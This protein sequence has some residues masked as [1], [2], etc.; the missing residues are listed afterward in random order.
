MFI[1]KINIK[2]FRHIENVELG[3]FNFNTKNSDLIV[4]AGPNGGGKSSMLEL[5]GYAL[6]SSYSLSW[7]LSRTFAGFSFEIAIG[8]NLIEKELI[9]NSLK[10]EL[11]N[12]ESKILD[13][14]QIIDTR[15]DINSQ[16]KERLK[17]ELKVNLKRPYKFQ[18]E[19][20]EYLLRNNVYYRSFEYN[21][22]EYA[23]NPA[24]QNQIHSYVTRELKDKLRRSLGFFLRSDRNYPQKGFNRNQIFAF[25]NVNKTEHL[26]TMAFNTSEIQY[27][28]MYESACSTTLSLFA[29]TW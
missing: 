21:E 10:I 11:Q 22:G 9:T 4:F 24:L 19:I 13:D 23:K 2:K 6:S 20:L 18:Y 1:N 25:E 26:W 7:Q 29:R 3:P 12:I 27:Q 15:Q 16:Q 8:L 5:I 17:L 14:T 28:D